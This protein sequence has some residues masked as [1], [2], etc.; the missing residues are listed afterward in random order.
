MS[1]LNIAGARGAPLRKSLNRLDPFGAQW[2][3][4]CYGEEV[5]EDLARLF[6]QYAEFVRPSEGVPR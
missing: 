5:N 3:R 1:D 6:Q 2:T 4:W